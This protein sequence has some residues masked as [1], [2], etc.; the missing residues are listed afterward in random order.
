MTLLAEI[1]L[2]TVAAIAAAVCLAL[3]PKPGSARRAASPPPAPRERP[4]QLLRLERLVSL[5]GASAL[6]LHAYLR[7]LLVEIATWR[8]A[9]RGETLT[10]LSEATGRQVFGE[11]L[12]EIVRPGRPFPEDRSGPGVSTDELAAILDVLERL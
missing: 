1:A 8:L 4:E 10:R 11:R 12:W 9:A 2:I 6:Q 7:P 3:L 5:S